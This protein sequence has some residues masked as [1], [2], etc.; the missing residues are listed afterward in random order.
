MVC[1][2][3]VRL[4]GFVSMHSTLLFGWGRAA[5]SGEKQLATVTF[6]LCGTGGLPAAWQEALQTTAKEIS[7]FCPGPS[8]ACLQIVL[9]QNFKFPYT[10]DK[11]KCDHS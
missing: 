7:A 1:R 6:S 8:R 3:G 2:T 4:Q 9:L 11:P 5:V 10:L